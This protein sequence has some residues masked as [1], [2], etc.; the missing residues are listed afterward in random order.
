MGCTER[1]WVLALVYICTMD[2]SIPLKIKWPRK[3]TKICSSCCKADFSFHSKDRS[4]YLLRK[5]GKLICRS[6]IMHLH[7][8]N[9]QILNYN[10]NSG[11]SKMLR[12]QTDE[13]ALSKF[14]VAFLKLLLCFLGS[15][16][17]I[18]LHISHSTIL[19]SW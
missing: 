9:T 16:F 7:S 13:F 17:D 18:W 19:V 15:G 3:Q 1:C 6:Y 8:S 4:K 10:K 2:K 5:F 12:F 11:V 14:W